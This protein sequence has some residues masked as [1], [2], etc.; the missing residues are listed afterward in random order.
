MSK[1]GSTAGLRRDPMRDV[2]S[3]T[4]GAPRLDRHYISGTAGGDEPHP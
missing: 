3:T 1:K 2:G 4:Q